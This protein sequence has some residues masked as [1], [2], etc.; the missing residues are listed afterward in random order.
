MLIYQSEI[1]SFQFSSIFTVHSTFNM[2]HTISVVLLLLVCGYVTESSVLQKW[3]DKI[4]GLF[5]RE[6]DAEDLGES[7]AVSVHP[8]R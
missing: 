5:Q 3:N 4:E 2:S 8:C 1:R 6:D 7:K